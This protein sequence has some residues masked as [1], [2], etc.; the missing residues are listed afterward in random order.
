MKTGITILCSL[1]FISSLSAQ[2]FTM[3][4]KCRAS[5]EVAVEALSKKE[6]ANAN[7]LYLA[8]AKKCKTRDDKEAA[9]VGRAEAL[10]G[11]G[12]YQEAID[13]TA[14]ALKISKNKSLKAHFQRGVAYAKLGDVASSKNDLDQV[15][16][17]T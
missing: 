7:D 3:G 17:L 2:T 15:I 14:E 9:S 13:A 5:L 16:R 10:N 1:M 6:Y 8:F 4:K 11:L 12:K